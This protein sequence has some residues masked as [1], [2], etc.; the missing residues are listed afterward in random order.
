MITLKKTINKTI[1]L[2]SF[3]LLTIINTSC[4]QNNISSQTKAD[5]INELVS[6]YADYGKFNGAILVAEE[7]E[8]IYKKGFGFAN[9]E[10]DIPNQ[11]D[12]K[13]RIA[14]IT[15]QFTAMLILQLV[16]E[17]KLDLNVPISTY[18]PDY[19]KQN[20]DKITIHHLLTHTSGTPE[21]DEFIYFYDI[22]RNRHRPEEL[23]SIFAEGE[24]QFTPGEEYAYSNTGYVILGVIIEKI[25]GKSYAKA[26][27]DNIFTPLE[28]LNSG[29]DNNRTILKNR[30][31]GYYTTYGRGNY[32]N[33]NYLDMTI[34][35]AAGSIY[36]TVEDLY[37]W[38]QALYTDK[39]LPKK[40]RDL[41]YGKYI[42]A[43]SRYYGYGW[44]IADM[45]VGNTNEKVQTVS[46]GGGMD[47]FR[48]MIT[49]IPS[50]KS[51]I[52]ILSNAEKS[53]RY[54]ITKAIIGILQNKTYDPKISV[55]YSLVDVI[56]KEG[57]STGLDYY[58][59]VKDAEGYYLDVDEL[60]MAGYELLWADREKD[61]E[62]VFKLN[63]EAFP[64]SFI[65]YDSYGEMLLLLGKKDEAIKNYRKSVELNPNNKGAL[66]VLEELEK[67]K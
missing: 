61:A 8:V 29:Y 41:L 49:R 4:G 62:T 50:S 5:K 63:V 25:S 53:P 44:F 30:A 18:L 26:L 59:E 56:L 31:S 58:T 48:T 42:P 39:L 43:R 47:G 1:L 7:G 2:A 20:A 40:Y 46:H 22:E 33:A 15:K 64:N 34:P 10:W 32:I 45:Q 67:N 51:S 66:R 3:A 37:I 55:A 21:F 28:M 24:L 35:Y 9:M 19:P 12:T 17:K 57:I 60:N 23:L 16:A 27:Q 52:I 6:R 65:V 54:E 38:D 36:S 11:T 14:S 13:F